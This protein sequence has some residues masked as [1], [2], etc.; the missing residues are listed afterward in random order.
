MSSTTYPG[1]GWTA[2]GLAVRERDAIRL[3]ILTGPARGAYFIGADDVAAALDGETVP[4]YQLRT[5]AGEAIPVEAGHVRTSSSGRMIVCQI[6]M[7]PEIV[8]VP[9]LALAAHY[10]TQKPTRIV[11]PPAPLTGPALSPGLAG[12]TA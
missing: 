4:L 3:E 8:Q 2:I 10:Q 9:A 5:R 11:T 6:D 1:N 12:V 7:A